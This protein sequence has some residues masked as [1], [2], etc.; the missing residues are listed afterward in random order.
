MTTPPSLLRQFAFM[1]V[2]SLFFI[3]CAEKIEPGAGEDDSAPAYL[4][5]DSDRITGDTD[6]QTD[7]GTDSGTDTDGNDSETNPSQTLALLVDDFEDGDNL[8]LLGGFWYTYSDGGNGGASSLSIERDTDGNVAMTGEGY[9]STTSLYLSFNLDQGDYQWAPYVGWGM[10]F[11]E[12]DTAFDATPYAGISYWYKGAAH[13]MRIET[14]DVTDWDYYRIEV[15]AASDWTLVAV[16]FSFFT[17]AG[18]GESVDMVLDHVT[19]LSWEAS[20]VTGQEGEMYIDNLGFIDAETLNIEPDLV[21]RDADV[22][23]RDILSSVT[24]DSELQ[25]L[26]MTYLNQGYNL[27]NWLEQ[28]K[29]ESYKFDQAYVNQLAAAGFKALRLPVDLDLYIENRD[30]YFAGEAAFAVEPLLFEI[31]DNF[32]QWTA[33]A[34]LSL[35]IDFHQYDSSLDITD[36]V[37]VDAAVALWTAV[38]EHFAANTR[39]D[40]FYE[41]VN[42]PELSAGVSSVDAEPYGEFAQQ[43]IDGIRSVDT[44]HVILFGDVQWNSIGLLTLRTPFT[45]DRM[46]YVFHFYE[47]FVFTHQGASWSDMGNTR[48]IPYPYDPARWSEYSSDFGFMPTQPDWH[49]MAL[50]DYYRKGNANWMYNQIVKA[51][52]WGV[53]NGVPVICNEFGVYDR[54]VQREDYIN[55][56]TDVIG[57]F[58]ELEIPWQTWFMIMDSTTGE[59]PADLAAAFGL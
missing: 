7:S 18:W 21:I 45:D 14:S 40:I 15:D 10:T 37:Y 27:T 8:S 59:V 2:F 52:R 9:E 17:Q 16:P 31:L 57:L 43:L 42:E 50:N 30:E 58:E 39:E 26:A 32:E 11:F 3:Q 41:L 20:G 1:T 51:K 55:Y 47:P 22:P 12:G 35:T 29:F 49:F 19:Q 23:E 44:T 33:E 56:Y 4:D 53:E 46:V 38:A 13:A 48:N 5:S 54:T 34:G 28:G 36:P 6:S 24:I 25:A